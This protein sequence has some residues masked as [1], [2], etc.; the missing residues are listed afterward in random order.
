MPTHLVL[1]M[2]GKRGTSFLA[3][4]SSYRT[5]SVSSTRKIPNIPAVFSCLLLP[6]QIP[7]RLVLT[8]GLHLLVTFVVDWKASQPLTDPVERLV[9][10]MLAPH[11]HSIN[12][13]ITT[14]KIYNNITTSEKFENGV[15][16]LKTYQVIS[17][18]TTPLR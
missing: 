11:P 17:V 9:L 18:H 16:A 4:C 2:T 10:L 14:C 1:L 12:N 3:T 13:D 6:S 15:Y 8:P 7:L 5:V